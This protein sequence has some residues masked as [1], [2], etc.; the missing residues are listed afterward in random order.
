M[1]ANTII[2]GRMPTL[3]N[4]AVS[5]EE[6]YRLALANS[7]MVRK[8]IKARTA[9]APVATPKPI[10][11]MVVMVLVVTVVIINFSKERQSPLLTY[12]IMRL[13]SR[14]L[15]PLNFMPKRG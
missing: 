1:T 2:S 13:L 7:L 9:A 14:V 15:W 6:K 5:C 12:T 3:R 10:T 4:L 8:A 11:A